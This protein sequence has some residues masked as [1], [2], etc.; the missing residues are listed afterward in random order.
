MY[1]TILTRAITKQ[2]AHVSILRYCI[3]THELDAAKLH[4]WT[5]K[6]QNNETFVWFYG[7]K[8]KSSSN[9]LYHVFSTIVE[10]NTPCFISKFKYHEM[11]FNENP[12]LQKLETKQGHGLKGRR[13][14]A[15]ILF[16]LTEQLFIAPSPWVLGNTLPKF[17][18]VV[19][20]YTI[21][22]SLY[23][24]GVNFIQDPIYLGTVFKEQP[25]S[26]PRS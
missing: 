18:P 8:M 10:T 24:K 21:H 26:P 1:S 11:Q 9:K 4:S 12:C 13:N 14:W 23:T 2:A 25:I 22:S 19:Y 3:I 20:T 17:C 15:V 16:S 6:H 5:I 7:T